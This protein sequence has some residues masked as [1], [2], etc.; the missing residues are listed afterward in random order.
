MIVDIPTA[1]TRDVPAD[2]SRYTI[3]D[4]LNLQGR[5]GQGVLT[6]AA[7]IET[8]LKEHNPRQSKKVRAK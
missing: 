4:L 1:D 7:A 8:K 6:I 2:L 5:L 3:A